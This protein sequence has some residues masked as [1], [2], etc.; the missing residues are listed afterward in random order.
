MKTFTVW[1]CDCE[2]VN[3]FRLQLIKYVSAL[4]FIQMQMIF[5]VVILVFVTFTL[6]QNVGVRACG[7]RHST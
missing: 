4:S 2:K 6:A 1:M 3:V 5:N 7:V